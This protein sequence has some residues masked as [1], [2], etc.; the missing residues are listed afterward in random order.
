MSID[1]MKRIS[2]AEAEA[3][4]I[5]RQA[6][7]DA[8]RIAEQGKQAAES[9]VEAAKKT[10]NAEYQKT[11]RQAEDVANALYE[12]RLEEVAAECDAMKERAAA[13]LPDAVKVITGK[14]VNTSVNG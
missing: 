6:Q 7:I 1:N 10:A 13:K 8:R 14:V 12:R 3:V 11:I 4:S 5:R 9:M 2:E